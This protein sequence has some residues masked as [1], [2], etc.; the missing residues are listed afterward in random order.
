MLEANADIVQGKSVLIGL[1]LGPLLGALLGIVIVSQ[2]DP[3]F[4]M[5]AEFANTMQ[6]TG[7]CYRTTTQSILRRWAA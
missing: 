4:A 7:S 6:P 1:I 5:P 2:L 3:I